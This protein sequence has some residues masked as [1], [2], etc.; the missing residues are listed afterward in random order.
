MTTFS[1]KA[2][3]AFLRN[4]YASFIERC[5]RHLHPQSEYLPNWHIEAMAAKLDACRRGKLLRLII[6]VPPR[7][8]KSLCASVALPAWI[9]G[10]DPSAQILCVSYA[11]DLADKLARDCLLVMQ[12]DWY[13]EL[14]PQTRLSKMRLAVSEFT[15]TRQGFRKATSV[16]GVLT[17][18]GADFIIIDDPLKP[19]EALSDTQRNK[20]NTWFGNT[21]YSRQNDK[22]RGC[23]ILIMQRLHEGDLVGHVIQQ[24]SWD[25]LCLPAIAQ[26]DEEHVIETM[27]G[28]ERIVRKAGEPLHVERES[29]EVLNRI[30]Q[31]MGT[32]DFAGQYLQAPAP[33]EGGIVK[34]KW[35]KFYDAEE[36]PEEFDRI[37]QSWDTASKATELANYSVCTTW[38]LKGKQIYLL[39]VYRKQLDFPGLVRAA[40]DLSRQ[41]GAEVVLVEEAASGIQLVQQLKTKGIYGVK[42]VKPEGDKVM[43][44]HAQ[45]TAIENGFAVLPREACWLEEYLHELTTFPRSKHSDQ[46][47]STSQALAWISDAGREPGILQYYREEAE[48]MRRNGQLP[49]V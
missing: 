8:L 26:E 16:D 10:R 30:K 28:T 42:A 24:E 29:L 33:L 45:S 2:Y 46:V 4:D 35:F 11:Q 25:L 36:Q 47:D 14:F 22:G 7:Y 15:T 39:N 31:T 23:I 21:L 13:R 41:F 20:V 40:E 32:Y 44:L 6:N 1:L 17:G 5:F 12:A 34:R 48:R 49:P 9:L 37:I 43:R 3:R 18:R 27:F 19:E 38:G